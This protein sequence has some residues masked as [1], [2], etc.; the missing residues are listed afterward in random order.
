MK[1]LVVY[2]DVI[3]GEAGR[4][5]A[6]DFASAND[7]DDLKLSI[8]N[9]ALLDE[10]YF[11]EFISQQAAAADM[12]VIA[13]RGRTGLT[14]SLKR[15]IHRW[16]VQEPLKHRALA[17]WLDYPDCPDAAHATEFLKRVARHGAVDFFHQHGEPIPNERLPHR[18]E[19]LWVF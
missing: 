18:H 14:Q 4:Q 9:A 13:I 16:T 19:V 17:V 3:A 1:A 7:F 5:V 6:R 10:S 12:I 8:W 11:T 15:W 2:E